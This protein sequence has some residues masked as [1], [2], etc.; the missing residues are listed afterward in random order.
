MGFNDKEC[1]KYFMGVEY[2]W[3][4]DPD[5]EFLEQFYEKQIQ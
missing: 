2:E 1:L 3:E 5:E 4:E